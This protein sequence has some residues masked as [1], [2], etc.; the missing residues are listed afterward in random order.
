MALFYYGK[1]ACGVERVGMIHT[2]T[3][4]ALA[5]YRQPMFSVYGI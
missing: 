2:E 5:Y 1:P 4:T 3:G